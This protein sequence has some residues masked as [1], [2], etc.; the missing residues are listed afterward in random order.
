MHMLVTRCMHFG[1]IGVMVHWHTDVLVL[2]WGCIGIL[3]SDV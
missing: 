1:H 3:E 2:V